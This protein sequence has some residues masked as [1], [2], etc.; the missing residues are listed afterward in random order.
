MAAG[1]TSRTIAKLLRRASAVRCRWCWDR[2]ILGQILANLLSDA[3]TFVPS[4]RKPEL[5][6]W[7]SR[8]FKLFK[9]FH[10]KDEYAELES[11][12]G[13]SSEPLAPWIG[14]LG[15]SPRRIAP[16][17]PSGPKHQGYRMAYAPVCKAVLASS[18]AWLNRHRDD[19]F[20]T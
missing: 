11:G 7:A 14:L 6:I 20:P 18:E 16:P 17:G 15:K 2:V 3:L 19:A 13:L 4:D 9:S 12:S 10:T 5:K 8:I 1:L